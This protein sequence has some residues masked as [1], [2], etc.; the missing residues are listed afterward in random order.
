MAVAVEEKVVSREFKEYIRDPNRDIGID[1]TIKRLTPEKIEKTINSVLNLRKNS[2]RFLAPLETCIHCGLCAPACQWYLSNDKDP[3]YAPVA[4]VR[5]TLWEMIKRNG[6]VDAEF[7][8]QCARIVF[9]EC[10]ICHRCSMYCPYGLDLT[11]QIGMVRRICFLLGVVPQFQMDQDHSYA[12]TLNQV[13]LSQNDWLDSVQWQEEEAGAELK[14]LRIPIDK[15]GA[16]VAWFPLGAE[17]K[18]GVY[19]IARIAK[20]MNV[21]GIDWTVPAADVWDSANMGMFIRDFVT[22]NRIVRGLFENAFRL[23]VKKMVLTE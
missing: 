13:W 14:N 7:I 18:T 9:T 12:A 20:I 10:N 1:E 8:K 21:A 22:M 11:Y 23:R 15:E 6:K 17:P 2:G 5:M 16:E 4:K 3:T 19:H